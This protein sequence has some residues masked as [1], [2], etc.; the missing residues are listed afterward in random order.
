MGEGES[1]P[2]PRKTGLI[3]ALDVEGSERAVTMASKTARHLDAVKVSIPSVVGPLAREG[4]N[5]IER[6]RSATRKP[7]IADW[8]VADVPHM[9]A[10]IVD[11]VASLGANA[12][13]V[14]GFMGEDSVKACVDEAEKASMD[15]FVVVE[16]SSPGATGVMQPLGFELAKLAKRCGA[17][18]IIAPGTRPDRVKLYRGIIGT[19]MQM[20]SPGIGAQGAEPGSAI[21]AGA[22]FEIV[23]R[24]IYGS[25][26]PEKEAGRVAS[27]TQAALRATKRA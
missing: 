26:D 25:R 14:H 11:L 16:L 15:V 6:L 3:L 21:A 18:G 27:I 13:I 22:D 23:G 24:S 8:K 1:M 7:V 5:V 20:L 9:D 10:M 19:D 2:I 12:V 17:T 4:V